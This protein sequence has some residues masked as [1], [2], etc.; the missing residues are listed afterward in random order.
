MEEKQKKTNYKFGDIAQLSFDNKSWNHTLVVVNIEN[1]FSLSDI[2]IASHTFDS[3]NKSILE[4]SFEKIRF[5][6]IEKVRKWG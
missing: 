2:K 5:I 3:Y 4:Y 6:H 1:R